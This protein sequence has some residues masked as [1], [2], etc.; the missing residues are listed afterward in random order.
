M[1][2]KSNRRYQD[3]HTAAGNVVRVLLPPV[4]TGTTLV[5]HLRTVPLWVMEVA[6]YYICLG[7]TSAMATA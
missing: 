1:V 3:L 6:T 4:P 7:A 2:D 5:D